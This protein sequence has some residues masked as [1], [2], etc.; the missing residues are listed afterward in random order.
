MGCVLLFVG[1]KNADVFTYVPYFGYVKALGHLFRHGEGAFG[2]KS[3][4]VC[5]ATAFAGV[6]NDSYFVSFGHN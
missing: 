2:I 6:N 5:C 1:G 4:G 3:L